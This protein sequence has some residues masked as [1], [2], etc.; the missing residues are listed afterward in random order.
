MSPAVQGQLFTLGFV[1]LFLVLGV[2]RRMRPQPVRPGR[3]AVS[4]G[5]IVL[6]LGVSLVGTGGRI[7]ADPVALALV[8]VFLVL[9]GL[10]GY[11]LVR[12]LTF[13]N[14]PDTGA[15]WMRGGALFA[16]ILVA[17]IAIRFGARAVA[18]GSFA[19]STGG[20]SAAG[21]GHGLLYDLSADLLF[22]S[23][24]LWAAR[25]FFVIRRFRAEAV[26]VS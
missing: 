3:I 6:L 14:D 23:L 7:I 2:S 26:A 25:A 18:T 1:L 9:G 22:L 20:F 10:A 16:I 19:G 17:T 8:P 24:G 11:Y 15:L 12:T 21:S 4:G 13:W 5:I